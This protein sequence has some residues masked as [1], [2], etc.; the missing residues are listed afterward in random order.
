MYLYLILQIAMHSIDTSF[1]FAIIKSGMED[2][3]EKMIE[4]KS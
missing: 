4:K 2:I 1:L 3:S